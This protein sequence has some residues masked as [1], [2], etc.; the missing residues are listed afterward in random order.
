MVARRHSPTASRR[1]D[2]FSS[3]PTAVG[4]P[5]TGVEY[6]L[7]WCDWGEDERTDGE[8]TGE[9]GDPVTED[10]CDA[11]P[12]RAGVDDIHVVEFVDRRGDC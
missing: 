5:A 11:V 2:L 12:D 9:V 8:A 10:D 6:D 7:K 1:R 4:E 3:N